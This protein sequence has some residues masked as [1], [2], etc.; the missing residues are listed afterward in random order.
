MTLSI[1][2]EDNH[3]LAISKPAGL[4][5]QGDH[6]GDPSVVTLAKAYLKNKYDKPGNV[7]LGLVHRLDRPVSGAMILARTSKAAGRLSA[8]FRQKQPRKHYFA[9]VEG[10]LE[11]RH[12]WTDH[13]VSIRGTSQVVPTEQPGAKEASLSWAA[14]DQGQGCTLVHVQLQTGRKHQIRCQFAHRGF[15]LLGDVRYGARRSFDGRNLALHSYRLEITHP[16]GST[17]LDIVSPLT[18]AWRPWVDLNRYNL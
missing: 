14:L 7:Y 13:L 15:P 12:E 16:V 2:H 8:A 11:G 3:V 18:S 17:P 9:L 10:Y 6:T 5:S 1:L 4:L